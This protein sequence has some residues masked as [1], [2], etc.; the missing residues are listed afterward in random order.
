MPSN[1]CS[2]S[3]VLPKVSFSFFPFL[4]E[5]LILFLLFLFL[6]VEKQLQGSL[7][8]QMSNKKTVQSTAM[9]SKAATA[10]STGNILGLLQTTEPPLNGNFH[11]ARQ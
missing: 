5:I 4:M 2:R 9:T 8:P 6:E 7:T 3:L 1:T 11:I 10:G